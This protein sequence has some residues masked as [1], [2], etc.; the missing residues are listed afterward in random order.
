M[1]CGICGKAIMIV[2]YSNTC[3]RVDRYKCRNSF[4]CGNISHRYDEINDAIVEEL[5]KHLHDFEVKYMEDAPADNEAKQTLLNSLK[6]N[7]E[8]IDKKMNSICEYL[9]SGLYTADMFLSRKKA[10]EEEKERLIVAIENTKKEMHSECDLEEK[11]ITLYK[12]LNMLNDDSISAKTKNIFLKTFI[13]V[14]YYK[15]NKEDGISLDIIL[16]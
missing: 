8:E 1:K 10:L 13:K 16:R 14:I 4:N 11:I 15:K 9:E 12:S 5:K 7:F 2:P 6:K 3:K